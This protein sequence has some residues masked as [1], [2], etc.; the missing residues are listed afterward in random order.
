MWRGRSDALN[1]A[2]A[3]PRVMNSIR[4]C[5][6]VSWAPYGHLQR[7]STHPSLAGGE[8]VTG[9]HLRADPYCG[10]HHFGR[11]P[12]LGLDRQPEPA[13]RL[14]CRASGRKRGRAGSE[15]RCGHRPREEGSTGVKKP[16]VDARAGTRSFGGARLR[17]RA[18]TGGP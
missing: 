11:A 17:D 5:M 6:C 7:T 2:A 12:C 1:C 8:G 9:G 14:E 3:S 10:E 4:S 13:R 18:A 15:E 16:R